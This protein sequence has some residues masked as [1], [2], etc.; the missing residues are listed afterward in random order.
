M[1]DNAIDADGQ[2]LAYEAQDDV[3]PLLRVCR[4]QLQIKTPVAAKSETFVKD[5]EA[6]STAMREE[7]A[8]SQSKAEPTRL[9]W[10]DRVEDVRNAD[11]ARSV[12][13]VQKA[14]VNL[15]A[16]LKVSTKSTSK[17]KRTKR[18]GGAGIAAF[19]SAL[20][21]LSDAEEIARRSVDDNQVRLS[22]FISI[23]RCE[24]L[25]HRSPSTRPT[26]FD[27][28]PLLRLSAS[29]TPTCAPGFSPLAASETFYSPPTRA[30]LPSPSSSTMPLYKRSN[31]SSKSICSS[32]TAMLPKRWRVRPF[33]SEVSGASVGPPIQLEYRL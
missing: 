5:W 30:S 15:E 16:S 20:S 1:A 25:P 28:L 14:L 4:H 24:L 29:L 6:L 23:E 18:L 22:S 9:Q 33:S 32:T 8:K 13:K 21:A 19:D 17:R 7:G 26:R 12:A 10:R 11:L 3:S 27:L 31:S 2:A